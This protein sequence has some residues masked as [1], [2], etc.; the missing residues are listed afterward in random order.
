M[1]VVSMG[2]LLWWYDVCYVLLYPLLKALDFSQHIFGLGLHFEVGQFAVLV[3]FDS[4]FVLGWPRAFAASGSTHSIAEAA[5]PC[6]QRKRQVFRSKRAALESGP[7]DFCCT[8]FGVGLH[9]VCFIRH[10]KPP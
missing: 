10:R 1:M 2:I 3:G 7:R 8:M 4:Q 9:V 6:R 5:P